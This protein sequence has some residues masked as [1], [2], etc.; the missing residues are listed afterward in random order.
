[1]IKKAASVLLFLVLGAVI[2][3]FFIKPSDYIIRFKANTFPGAINQTLKL[4]DQTL[5]TVQKI[6]QD[7]DL[8]H[9]SQ[10]LRFGDSIHH[11][12]WHIVPITDSTSKVKVHIK[13]CNLSHSLINK[14][15]IPFRKT[16]FTIQS[17]KMV[18]DFMENLKKH[19]EKFS[20]TVVG[21]AET[22]SKF[23][24]YV[25][26]EVT[27]FQKAGGMMRNY[28]Y[29]T[30]ELYGRGVQFDGPPMVIVN[31]WDM[32]NDSI[33]YDFAQPIIRSEKLPHGTDIKYRRIFKKPSLKAEYYGNYITSDRAWYAL[34]DYAKKNSIVLEPTPIEVFHNNPNTDGDELTWKA[35]IFIPIKSPE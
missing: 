19:T 13:D 14:L 24:A 35:E 3:Y 29:L 28:N 7:G 2:W 34:L 27:Q 6:S 32:N 30:G 5:D 9:L 26:L 11:Y 17:E 21:E 4:W 1:M 22:P 10:K 23:L 15:K 18:M 31:R 8:Y 20:V 25:P 16:D 12:S 33:F